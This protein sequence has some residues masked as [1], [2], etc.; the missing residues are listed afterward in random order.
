MLIFMMHSSKLKGS[1]P[2]KSE[3]VILSSSFC[4]AVPSFAEIQEQERKRVTANAPP[5]PAVPSGATPTWSHAP[6]RSSVTAERGQPDRGRPQELQK[7]AAQPVPPSRA[8]PPRTAAQKPA[9]PK[10]PKPLAA[11][12]VEVLF[13]YKLHL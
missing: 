3:G 13:E 9:A 2:A 11:K 10:A 4:L 6:P 5:P 1:L 12:P 8:A 7:K